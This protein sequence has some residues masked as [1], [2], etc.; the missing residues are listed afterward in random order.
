MKNL[1]TAFIAIGLCFAAVSANAAADE[2]TGNCLAHKFWAIP[3]K[4]TMQL[5]FLGDQKYF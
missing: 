1:T 4:V 5:S 2:G 3:M